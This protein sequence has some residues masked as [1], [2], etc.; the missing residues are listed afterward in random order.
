[1]FGYKLDNQ[2]DFN[3]PTAMSNSM[4][5][6]CPALIT[7]IATSSMIATVDDNDQ[8]S[9]YEYYI[10]LDIDALNISNPHP[11]DGDPNPTNK[12][13]IIASDEAEQARLVVALEPSMNNG[14]YVIVNAEPCFPSENGVLLHDCNILTTGLAPE[15]YLQRFENIKT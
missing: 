4:R 12:A 10:N 3:G 7:R 15:G 11:N 5:L 9:F 2:I 14:W 13:C 8:K 1:M 6:S